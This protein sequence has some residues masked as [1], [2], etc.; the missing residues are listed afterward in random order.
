ML[1]NP[2]HE[3]IIETKMMSYDKLRS[4]YLKAFSVSFTPNQV[5]DYAATIISILNDRFFIEILIYFLTM[6]FS[7][8]T[9]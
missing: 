9:Y 7:N 1:E 4:I 6:D 8:F 3:H 2:A 5:V